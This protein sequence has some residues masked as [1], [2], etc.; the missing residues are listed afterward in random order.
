MNYESKIYVSGHSG[1]VGSALI[2][3]LRRAGFSNIVTR[4]HA[5]LDL[6]DQ[7]A[8]AQ[9]FALE[10]P[11]YVFLFAGKVGGLPPIS[12]Y[13]GA[14]LYENL[15]IQ[16]NVMHQAYLHGVRKLLF[17]SSSCVYPEHCP[18]P[19]RPEYILTGS[20]EKGSEPYGVAK[21]AGIELCHN[22]NRQYGTNYIAA[23]PATLYGPT[24]HFDLKYAHVL[25]A[26]LRKFHEAKLV[27]HSEVILWGTGTPERE[28][29]YVE[30]FAE[31]CLFLMKNY[32]AKPEHYVKRQL[33][34]NVGT[35]ESLTISA[36]ASAVQSIVGFKG[37][38]L[39]D[40]TRS[41]GAKRKLLDSSIIHGLGWR[42]TTALKNG[43]DKTYT[44]LQTQKI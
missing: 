25:D 7:H 23:V 9:F 12:E 18:Q 4:I 43:I 5:E 22:Y 35:G 28:F 21:L 41:D 14:F 44:W 15:Q 13:P 33:C 6:L 36:L 2:T 38:I 42:H 29:L 39:W 8:V 16:N 20:L 17:V 11:E 1:M 34:V 10:R 32:N 27:N 26:L 31:A 30:D 40:T 3:A 37:N 19:M 24:P